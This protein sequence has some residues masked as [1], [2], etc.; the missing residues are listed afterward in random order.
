MIVRNSMIIA[1]VQSI[2][3]HIQVTVAQLPVEIGIYQVTFLREISIIVLQKH[4]ILSDN[5]FS[6]KG[7]ISTSSKM[8]VIH[9]KL[10]FSNEFGRYLT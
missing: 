2:K 1:I 6:P 4:L 3:V 5:F 8:S 10:Q 9:R 7:L